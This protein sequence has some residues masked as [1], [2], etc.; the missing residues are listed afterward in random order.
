MHTPEIPSTTTSLEMI[1]RRREPWV[2]EMVG[3]DGGQLGAWEIQARNFVNW[4]IP[5]QETMMFGRDLLGRPNGVWQPNGIWQPRQDYDAWDWTVGQEEETIARDSLQRRHLDSEQRHGHGQVEEV[6]NRRGR[7]SYA[8]RGWEDGGWQRMAKWSI[9]PTQVN[10][11]QR[12]IQ[13]R[14][15]LE[16]NRDEIEDMRRRPETGRE[17]E[18]GTSQ[19]ESWLEEGKAETRRARQLNQ[20]LKQMRRRLA[21]LRLQREQR[22]Q[23]Q[24]QQQQQQHQRN[25]GRQQRLSHRGRASWR[26]QNHSQPQYVDL[27]DEEV[28]QII[29]SPPV[30][31][32]PWQVIDI[33]ETSEQVGQTGGDGSGETPQRTDIVAQSPAE[34]K[35]ERTLQCPICLESLLRLGPGESTLATSC[36]H[37][38]CS[39]C[40]PTALAHS[41]SCPTCRTCLRG[42][43]PTKIFL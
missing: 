41:D 14:R 34:N 36:G 26:P 9:G 27:G 32:L 39:S 3:R 24:Q 20:S 1:Q 10:E 18:S 23:R 4:E 8:S 40:L 30:A 33:T 13:L 29:E 11:R 43:P 22:R 38:F 28:V 42:K 12:E 21:E 6:E 15:E 5:I 37:L 25:G 31:R 2:A 7:V 19:A 17:V 35:E 16:R